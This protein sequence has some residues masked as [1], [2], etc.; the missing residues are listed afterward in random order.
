M[1]GDK[2]VVLVVDGVEENLDLLLETLGSDYTVQ[3]ALDGESAL[4]AAARS[5]PDLIL[6]D[7]VMSGIDGFE[8]CRR[9][10]ESEIT[11]DIP[12][13]FLT[14]LSDETDETCGLGLGAV[15]YITKPF[16][17][18][19]LRARVSNHIG[20]KRH[21]DNLEA[22]V[23]LKT[24]DL[25][26]TKDATIAS[27]AFLAEH[28]DPE[29][30]G[31][32]RRIRYYVRS[33]AKD[34]S[35]VYP[36]ELGP[37]A[38]ELLSRSAQL[39]DIGK[40]G[41]R[42]SI[43]LKPG[44]LDEEEFKEIKTHTLIGS[45]VVRKTEAYLGTN[46]FLRMAREIAEFHHERWDGSGY[47]HGLRGEEIPLCARIVAIADVYDALVTHRPYKRI[48]SY[49]EAFRIIS[50]GDRF[51]KPEHFSPVILDSF[52]RVYKEWEHIA[53]TLADW[54]GSAEGASEVLAK[55]GF[56]PQGSPGE[57]ELFCIDNEKEPVL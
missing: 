18:A 25:E 41:V 33:M 55:K 19:V 10:K 46:S 14:A 11:R 28:R 23:R 47:P 35:S 8:V 31:H 44:D 43:L 30:E 6:L 2:A 27:L 54:P 51:T 45:E 17:P 7:V 39:H 9:M 52:R 26:R 13:I 1:T 38:I 42:D 53:G 37:V 32:I 49:D 22:L 50:A 29:T 3:V 36:D 48:F 4:A 40:V 15:D 5:I 20:L 16:S 34:L 12:V 24:Y 56:V 57:H 21:K